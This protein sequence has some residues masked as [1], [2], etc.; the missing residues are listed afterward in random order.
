MDTPGPTRWESKYS[1]IGADRPVAA[2]LAPFAGSPAHLGHRRA[3]RFTRWLQAAGYEV[4]I[5][6][7]RSNSIEGSMSVPVRD[8]LGIW[9]W[10]CPE[11]D[12]PANRPPRRGWGLARRVL[13]PDPSILWALRAVS[14]RAARTAARNSSVLISTGP[15]ESPHIAASILSRA[16]GVPHLMDYRDGWLDEP[17]KAEIRSRGPRRSAEAAIESWALHNACAVTVTSDVWGRELSARHPW[18]Q[19]RLHTITNVIPADYRPA[20]TRG[21]LGFMP[22]LVYA[23]RL[24]GSRTC[25]SAESLL[26]LLRL[27]A[28][29]SPSPFEVLFVGALHPHE[30]A[31]IERFGT[32]VASFGW[33]VGHKPNCDY[34]SALAEVAQADGLLLVSASDG[35]VPS[36]L[37]DYL[38]T[39][40]PILCISSKGSA[41]WNLCDGLDQVWA[42]DPANLNGRVGFCATSCRPGHA[43]PPVELSESSVSGRF[44]GLIDQMVQVSTRV[45]VDGRPLS[46]GGWWGRA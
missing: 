5:I 10:P 18:L 29:V 1:G 2:I 3:M 26:N 7:A 33:I 17:L 8:P 21:E 36:K 12:P 24:S 14:S 43:L 9:S 45:L 13:I 31:E 19:G 32:E 46:R 6:G 15:P 23:G 25:Q 34:Q 37:Y 4:I 28:R 39:G 41:V 27:E 35:A 30:L 40:R 42:V 44:V 20:A 16:F 22:R 38:A 11:P